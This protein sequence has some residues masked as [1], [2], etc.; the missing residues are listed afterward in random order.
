MKNRY[1]FGYKG[2]DGLWGLEETQEI[3]QEVWDKFVKEMNFL[4]S[5]LKDFGEPHEFKVIDIEK[6]CIFDE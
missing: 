5:M 2:A 6:R 4:V 1:A 3:T